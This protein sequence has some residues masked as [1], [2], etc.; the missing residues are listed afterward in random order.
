MC[1]FDSLEDL[2][3]P[4]FSHECFTDLGVKRYN[5]IIKRELMC[6]WHVDFDFL[7]KAKLSF[8]EK[9]EKLGY[10]KLFDVSDEVYLQLVSV[11]HANFEKVELQGRRRTYYT[12][13]VKDTT[14]TLTITSVERNFNLKLDPLKFPSSMPSVKAHKMCLQK[15]AH[16]TKIKKTYQSCQPYTLTHRSFTIFWSE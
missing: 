16:S 8:V 5:Y 1:K 11:F 13:K 2:G 4:E 12:T 15:Y 7:R 14:I 3:I 9:L 10:M 6:C